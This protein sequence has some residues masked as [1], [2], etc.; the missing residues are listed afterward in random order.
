MKIY[1]YSYPGGSGL[2][3]DYKDIEW[4]L[5]VQPYL[6]YRVFYDEETAVEFLKRYKM[7]HKLR[8]ISQYGNTFIDLVVNATYIIF[9]N[10]L[11]IN[12][13]KSNVPD[14]EFNISDGNSCVIER[15]DTVSIKISNILLSNRTI[16]G[17]MIAIYYILK[18]AGKFL[19][20]NIEIPDRS[21]YYALF[22]YT[23]ENEN[24]LRVQRMIK[25]RL[26]GFSVT[27]NNW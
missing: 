20:I 9:N 3:K 16:V 18:F 8:G 27:L 26:G 7:K 13:D 19:D 17:H 25:E 2:T 10:C 15:A 1:A 21:I 12:F 23:G 24:I 4:K 14:V 5:K 22:A 11:Y 6:K